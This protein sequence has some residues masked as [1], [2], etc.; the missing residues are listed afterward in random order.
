[1][2]KYQGEWRN[3]KTQIIEDFAVAQQRIDAG[4]EILV[5]GKDEYERA[6][7]VWKDARG[8]RFAETESGIVFLE[9]G[10]PFEII[11]EP[12]QTAVDNALA[13]DPQATLEGVL[14][15]ATTQERERG[16]RLF[17]GLV[18]RAQRSMKRSAMMRC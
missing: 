7:R 10:F 11:A 4:A 15:A 3:D 14:S 16:S 1:M 13:D 8:T 9:G 17:F 18:S 12:G 6:K 2:F 5:S